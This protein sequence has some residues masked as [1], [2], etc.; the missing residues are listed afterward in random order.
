MHRWREGCGGK[1]STYSVFVGKSE[2]ICLQDT[3]I[4]KKTKIWVLHYL[5][6]SLWT[7]LAVLMLIPPLSDGQLVF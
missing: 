5:Y 6:I 1:G 2:G 4:L 7:N 3:C